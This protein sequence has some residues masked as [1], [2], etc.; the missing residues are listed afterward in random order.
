[1]TERMPADRNSRAMSLARREDA[2]VVRGPRSSRC[3][4]ALGRP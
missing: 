4:P 1:V 2:S 3:R